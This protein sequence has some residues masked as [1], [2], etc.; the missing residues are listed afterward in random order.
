MVQWI[1]GMIAVCACLCQNLEEKKL[2]QKIGIDFPT[3]VVSSVNGITILKT[4][5]MFFLFY[6]PVPLYCMLP[7]GILISIMH[8]WNFRGKHAFPWHFAVFLRV[9]LFGIFYIVVM[10]LIGGILGIPFYRSFNEITVRISA[11]A[12]AELIQ[13]G[14]MI[15]ANHMPATRLKIVLEDKKRIGKLL[16]FLQFGFFYLFLDSLLYLYQVKDSRLNFAVMGSALLFL[17]QFLICFVYTYKIILQRFYKAEFLKREKERVNYVTQ[18]LTARN[19]NCRDNL[20]GIYTH[21]FAME[22]LENLLLEREE[23]CIAYIDVNGLKK[24]NDAMG[25][26]KGDEYLWEVSKIL[27]E[28]MCE[29]N[30]LARIGGDEFIIIAVGQTQEYL[31]GLLE[32]ANGKLMRREREEY[33]ASFSYGVTQIKKGAAYSVRKL[34]DETDAKMYSYKNHFKSGR[35]I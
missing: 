33:E 13:T 27:K 22:V 23:F 31:T 30:I 14:L 8:Y 32:S 34:L 24:V 9:I 29:G 2:Y 17:F 19:L 20:T 6:L 21:R 7:A 5:L 3:G 28:R 16:L 1:A 12:V 25:H 35:V 26:R 18:R 4:A 10:T 15:M 11:F